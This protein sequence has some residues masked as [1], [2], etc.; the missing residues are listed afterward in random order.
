[1]CIRR[2]KHNNLDGKTGLLVSGV[3][4][5]HE[6]GFG[7][8]GY[9]VVGFGWCLCGLGGIRGWG[10]GWWKESCLGFEIRVHSRV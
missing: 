4:S 3:V 5:F 8:I 2:W 1:M 6:A 10:L 9:D 7:M